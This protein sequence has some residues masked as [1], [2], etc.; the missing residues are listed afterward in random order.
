MGFEGVSFT[1]EDYYPLAVLSTALG[2][3]MSS[4]C[5][6]KFGKSGLVYRFIRFPRPLEMAEFSVFMPGP[7]RGNLPNWWMPSVMNCNGRAGA[8]G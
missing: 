5:S 1:D 8:D 7:A 6:R 3:G 2:G 4:A